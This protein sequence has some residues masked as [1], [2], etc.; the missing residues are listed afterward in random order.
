MI[1]MSSNDYIRCRNNK[2]VYH[3][4]CCNLPVRVSQAYM[5]DDSSSLPNPLRPV[6]AKIRFRRLE[7]E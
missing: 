2:Y 7:N 4:R 3:F 5:H 6:S 1:D